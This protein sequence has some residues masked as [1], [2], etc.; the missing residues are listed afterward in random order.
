MFTVSYWMQ[1]IPILY[2]CRKLSGMQSGKLTSYIILKFFKSAL[3]DWAL[4]NIL[5]YFF[6]F[7]VVGAEVSENKISG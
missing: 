7:Y 3:I 4:K 1:H 6:G 5:M 2:H